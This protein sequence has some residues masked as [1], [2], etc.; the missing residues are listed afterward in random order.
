VTQTVVATVRYRLG[1]R[2]FF[3]RQRRRPG[4]RHVLRQRD[5]TTANPHGELDALPGAAIRAIAAGATVNYTALA[6]MHAYG[7][8]IAIRPVSP[9]GRG[10]TSPSAAARARLPRRCWCR[11]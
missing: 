8:G 6:G 10:P 5:G 3:G 4:D 2:A 7:E 11:S 1:R 9:S